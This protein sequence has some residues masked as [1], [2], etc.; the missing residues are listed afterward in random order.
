MEDWSRYSENINHESSLCGIYLQNSATSVTFHF[1]FFAFVTSVKSLE[2]RKYVC[3]SLGWTKIR[4][5]LVS[6]LS[7]VAYSHR[8]R[9]D[10]CEEEPQK[11]KWLEVRE[12]KGVSWRGVSWRQ[13]GNKG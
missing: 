12:R 4:G 6:T 8:K 7:L 10:A 9:S 11:K 1:Q 3:L 13:P 5:A 2:T